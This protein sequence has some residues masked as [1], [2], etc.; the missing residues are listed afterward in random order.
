LQIILASASPRRIELLSKIGLRFKGYAPDINE[1]RLRNESPEKLVRRL[2]KE[3]A[4]AVLKTSLVNQTSIVI[5]ADTIVVINGQI[6][7]KPNDNSEAYKMLRKLSG[8]T[9]LVLTGVFVAKLD[10]NQNLEKIKSYGQVVKTKVTMKKLNPDTIRAYIRSGEP[11]DKAGAYA[12]QGLGMALIE[13]VNGS[14]SNVVGLPVAQLLKIF[15][16]KFDV[17]LFSWLK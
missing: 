17:P 13:K 11:K 9:H 3:K 6:L 2:S 12:A 4:L 5:A 10:K 14:Y 16:S 1:T 7:G 8:K 15:E